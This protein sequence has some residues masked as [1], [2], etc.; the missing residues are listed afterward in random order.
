MIAFLVWLWVSN[1]AILL[2]AELDAEL[3]RGRAIA[4]G[5]DPV[6]EPYLQLRDDRKVKNTRQRDPDLG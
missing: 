5:Q 4:A 1:V 3:E 2:G 6:K